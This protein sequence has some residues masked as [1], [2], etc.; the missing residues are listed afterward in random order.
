LLYPGGRTNGQDYLYP[1][2]SAI[3]QARQSSPA[4]RS[5]KRYFLDQTGGGGAQPQ[6]HSVAKYESLGASPNQSDVVFAFANLDRNNNQSTNF[7]V[8]ISQGGSNYFGI[9][10]GRTYNVKNIAAYTAADPNRRN[11]WLWGGGTAGSNVLANGIFVLLKKVPTSGAGWTTD[12]FEAQYLKLY[13]VTP[14]AAPATPTA[15]VAGTN[16]TF[17]WAALVDPDGGVSGYHLIV[18]NTPG[19]SNV[20]NGTITG[21]AQGVSGSYGQTLYAQVSAINNAGIEGPMSGVGSALLL[22]PNADDDGDGMSNGAEL[23]AG[24]NPFDT[25]SVLRIVSFTGG[26]LV[27][28]S[29]VSGKVY[30][31]LAT[32]SLATSL[33]PISGSIT[34]S[35]GVTS[36]PDPTAT[37]VNKFYRVQVLP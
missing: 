7:N 30:Q 11:V 8:N 14:P 32:P 37:N 19:G 1:V 20:F 36:F 4:L 18:G 33:T 35:V 21:T 29:S 23:F 25:N 13:D 6:I 31:V 22:D 27:S 2:Y 28:W 12:P 17:S 9:K 10:P 16:A 34:A 24:T 3:N 15:S 5:S 26:N